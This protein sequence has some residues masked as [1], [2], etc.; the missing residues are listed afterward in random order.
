MSALA[1]LV[2]I[3]PAGRYDRAGQ[4]LRD[5]CDMDCRR[6]DQQIAWQAL[7]ASGDE[8][9]PLTAAWRTAVQLR[10]G[11]HDA[12]VLSLRAWRGEESMKRLE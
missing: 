2:A 10:D 3:L 4:G 5:G 12:R 9:I 1:G 8:P 7:R 11:Y 6:A